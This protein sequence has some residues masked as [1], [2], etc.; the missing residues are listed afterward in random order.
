MCPDIETY[1]P[2]I[3]AGFGLV[4]V[5]GD[6]GHPAHRL[7]VRLADR[8]PGQTNPLLG[9][10]HAPCSTS[11]AAGP[12]RRS[13]RSETYA[14]QAALP[15]VKIGT[16][17]DDL[18]RRDFTIN[19]LAIRLDGAHF[20]ELRDD[21]GGW[22]DLQQGLI[23]VLHDGSFQDD[24]T[25]L[26]RAVRYE[27]RYQFRIADET[28][29]LMP[30]SRTLIS[31]LSAQRI[32]HELDLVLDEDRATAILQRLAEL[33]L[34]KPAHAA[35]VYDEA[36]ARRLAAYEPGAA[37]SLPHWPR[38]DMLWL[39]WLMVL[40]ESAIESL[41]RRL[42]FSSVLLK[43]ALAASALWPEVK[44]HARGCSQ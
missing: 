18:R 20:G 22:E 5:V 24:P 35:L 15:T 31:E 11:R 13:A 39:L 17:E 28:L 43:S 6:A 10:G 7:R 19:A 32:R 36:A 25:R 8:A 23:R 40:P 14:Y 16:I 26:Y 27:Q 2:L 30:G 41:N 42:H 33:E 29:A 9:R 38:R 3:E 4:D 34:L 37:L 44:G 1:A 12:R 21:L